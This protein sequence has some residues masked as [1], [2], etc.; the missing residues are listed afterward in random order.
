MEDRCY[1]YS[2]YLTFLHEFGSAFSERIDEIVEN[3]ELEDCKY[4]QIFETYSSRN[5]KLLKYI[6]NSLFNLNIDYSVVQCL[7][8]EGILTSQ[9]LDKDLNNKIR[10]ILDRQINKI[11]AKSYWNSDFLC[12]LLILKDEF[13]YSYYF[14][15]KDGKIKIRN[16]NLTP[17][18]SVD[19]EHKFYDSPNYDAM[20]D[21]KGNV[22]FAITYHGE[23]MTYLLAN[24]IDMRQG[25][26][27]A[28]CDYLDEETFESTFDLS[29][30][31]SEDY[32]YANSEDIEKD[33]Y[34]FLSK[35]RIRKIC[36]FMKITKP[37]LTK[38]E[39]INTFKKA[40]GFGYDF[41]STSIE[42]ETNIN[43][44]LAVENLTNIMEVLDEMFPNETSI[45]L[46][47]MCQNRFKELSLGLYNL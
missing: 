35:S 30:L 13:A 37:H 32:E 3:G 19:I 21:R 40:N 5:K 15:F 44:N 47:E 9:K 25:V 8:S 16:L 38:T 6:M 18:E 41:L 22:Y 26:R 28:D 45:N 24:S 46:V 39:M 23:L 11:S 12:M 42:N 4:F 29:S 31:A 34:V 33:K 7:L 36:E 20:M 10:L 17:Q 2:D 43:Y 27:I 1:G 14:T